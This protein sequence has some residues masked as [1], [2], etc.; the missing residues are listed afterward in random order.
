MQ[1]KVRYSLPAHFNYQTLAE[2]CDLISSAK[3]METAARSTV[4]YFTNLLGMKGAALMLLNRRSKKLELAASQ[5][6]SDYYLNKGPISASRSIAASISEGPVAIFNVSDDPRL[7]YPSEAAEE[8]IASLLSTP[9]VLRGKPMGV[10]RI[11]TAE[12]WEFTMDDI[13]FVQAVALML[14]LVLDNLRVSKAYKTSIEELK[15]LRA[16]IKPAKRTLHE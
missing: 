12:P 16:P 13:T 10:L 7:Q 6:L 4:H 11:Y 15:T 2:I 14:A 9:L 8:G 3:N 5:G 1:N